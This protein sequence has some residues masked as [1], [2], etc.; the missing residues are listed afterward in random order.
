MTPHGAGVRMARKLL[1]IALALTALA[2]C[3]AQPSPGPAAAPVAADLQQASGLPEFRLEGQGC[4]MGGGHSVHSKS[5]MRFVI[6]EPWEAADILADVG[7]QMVYPE[8]PYDGIPAE[9]NT[10]GNWHVTTTCESWVYNGQPLEDFVFGFVTSR[11][12]APPFDDGV[13]VRHYIMT[14][15]ATGDSAM[16]EAFH[17]AGF[18]AT[19]TTGIN[20]WPAP[21]LYHH[22][23]DTGDHGIYESIYR[24]AEAGEPDQ[25][26]TRLWW[27]SENEDGT[28]SPI[29]LDLDIKGGRHFWAEPNGYFSH[30]RTEDH[31]PLPGAAGN[32]AGLNWQDID[33]TATLGPRRTDVKLE[34][35]YIHL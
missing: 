9:G 35:A 8:E 27:Q 6:P 7:P 32:I 23:L 1:G 13:P 24:V 34:E 17:A 14:V 4:T 18:H 21:D 31:S 28:F 26:I 11:I 19:T 33:F 10:W 20:E 3:I 16:Q 29:A 25:G 5:V 22:V 15:L 12:E 30:L 2:G